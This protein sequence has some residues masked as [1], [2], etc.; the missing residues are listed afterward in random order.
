MTDHLSNEAI[1]GITV[2]VDGGWGTAT[3]WFLGLCAHMKDSI[4]HRSTIILFEY[5]WLLN[6]MLRLSF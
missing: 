4:Y 3:P 5:N 6:I 1:L 2:M